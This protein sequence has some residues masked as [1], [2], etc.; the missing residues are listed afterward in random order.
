MLRYE[1]VRRD[2]RK[3]LALTSLTDK[4]FKDVLPHFAQAYAEVY[5]NNRTLAGK[6][7]KRAVGGGRKSVLDET[8]QKLLFILVYQK[9][10]PLQVILAELFGMSQASVNEWIHR[11]LPVLGAALDKM[12]LMPERQGKNFAK[13]EQKQAQKP[14]YIIDGTERRRQRPQDQVEQALHY[15]G[16]KKIHSDKN[17]LIVQATS[18]RVCYLSPT[19]PGK[20]HD[21]K[22]ADQEK[23]RY[24]K[25][26][27][28]HKDTGFQGYEPK[29]KQSYQPKKI[30]SAK[31]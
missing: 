17:V 20:T 13:T 2:K 25:E 3:F 12:G 27:T 30:L 14:K 23:I 7:R 6:K 24:P 4:E 18:K 21:K 9:D 19:Y 15:S 10:Y 22:V 1:E 28:L 31:T 26:A 29:L 11:L 8:E 5:E 16:K